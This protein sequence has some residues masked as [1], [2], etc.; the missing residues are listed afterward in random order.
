M[1]GRVRLWKSVSGFKWGEVVA[2]PAAEVKT[3]SGRASVLAWGHYSFHLFSRMFLA[4]ETCQERGVLVFILLPGTSAA[5]T[6]RE[7][8][9]TIHRASAPPGPVTDPIVPSGGKAY[10]V[11]AVQAHA[12]EVSHDLVRRNFPQQCVRKFTTTPKQTGKLCPGHR[13]LTAS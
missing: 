6:Q 2:F 8:W 7:S 4:G 13:L 11:K 1:A 5:D 12:S 9:L 10:L 3:K